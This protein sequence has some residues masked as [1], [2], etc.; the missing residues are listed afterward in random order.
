MHME[1]R[2]DSEGDVEVDTTLF[3]VG[4]GITYDT[5]GSDVKA[6]GVMAGMHRDKCGAAAIVGF[7][8]TLAFLRP[9]GLRVVAHL[10]FVRNGV[11]P[12]ACVADE[13][14]TSRAGKRVRIGN[15][16]AEGRMIMTDLLCLAKEEVR[17]IFSRLING[18]CLHFW[19]S[20]ISSEAMS[21]RVTFESPLFFILYI[22]NATTKPP[23]ECFLNLLRLISNQP[24]Q[25]LLTRCI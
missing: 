18:L 25:Q 4:K 9:A 11:G 12:E 1:Y 14:I 23:A 8:R 5:G 10:A 13:I 24:L 22:N 7:M 17:D 2:G 3:L 6:G 19:S 20:P 15:T 16:D 21:R